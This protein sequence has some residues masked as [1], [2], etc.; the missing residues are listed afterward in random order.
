MGYHQKI[1]IRIYIMYVHVAKFAESIQWNYG[2]STKNFVL[3]WDDRIH[4]LVN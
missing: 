2:Q 4:Q 3:S 1:F